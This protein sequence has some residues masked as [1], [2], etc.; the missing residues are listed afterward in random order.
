MKA[1]DLRIEEKVRLLAGKN[2]WYTEDLGGKLYSVYC[3]DGPIGV[4]TAVTMD[5]DENNF[6]YQEIRY[7][8]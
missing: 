3:A 7:R 2:G 8:M 6:K 1:K 5:W 4:R